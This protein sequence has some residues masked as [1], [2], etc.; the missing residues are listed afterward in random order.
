MLGILLLTIAQKTFPHFPFAGPSQGVRQVQGGEQDRVGP[1]QVVHSASPGLHQ[2][3]HAAHRALP[4]LQQ[5]GGAPGG[6]R[7]PHKVSSVEFD[8]SSSWADF[9][10]RW[11]FFLNRTVFAFAFLLFL[12]AFRCWYETFKSENLFCELAHTY[13]SAIFFPITCHHR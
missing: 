12:P 7:L 6:D 8:G 11:R 5:A 1:R 10:N 13:L 4:L 2:G 3:A 9:F